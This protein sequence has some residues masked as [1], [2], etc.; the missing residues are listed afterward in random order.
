MPRI[1]L[2]AALIAAA[3][4]A[5]FG[6]ATRPARLARVRPEGRVGLHRRAAARGR[7]A[8]GEAA[9]DEPHTIFLKGAATS[10]QMVV[11]ENLERDGEPVLD[12]GD[13]CSRVA[14][15]EVTPEVTIEV[16]PDAPGK[17]SR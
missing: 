1:P 15:V 2:S 13:L 6:C 5:A 9:K 4:A 16:E 10:L 3:G 11:F 17:P 8:G 12:P 7:S 14:F